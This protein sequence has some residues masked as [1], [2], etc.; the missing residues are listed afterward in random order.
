MP[1]TRLSEIEREVCP[2]EEIRREYERYLNAK[3]GLNSLWERLWGH[4]RK[5]AINIQILKVNLEISSILH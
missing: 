2:H 3:K 1:N 4:D 5:G